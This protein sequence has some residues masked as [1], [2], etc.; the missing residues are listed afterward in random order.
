M[1]FIHCPYCQSANIKQ[2]ESGHPHEQYFE[3]LRHFISPAQMALFGIKI[4]KKTGAPTAVPQFLQEEAHLSFLL[5][6]G[7]F[8]G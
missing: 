5:F 7:D 8:I 1:S 3:Q 4:A 6:D 2:T